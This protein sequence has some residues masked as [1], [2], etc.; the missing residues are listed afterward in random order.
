MTGYDKKIEAAILDAGWINTS[1]F[2]QSIVD[3]IDLPE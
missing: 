3:T 2:E 1:S